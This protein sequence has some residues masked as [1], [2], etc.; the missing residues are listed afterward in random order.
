M[1]AISFRIILLFLCCLTVLPLAAQEKV[2]ALEREVSMKVTDE[3]VNNV[4]QEIAIQAGIKF[5]Y[6]PSGIPASKKVTIAVHKKTVR[7]VLNLLFN[8]TV[9]YRQHGNFIILTA[10][11]P[12]RSSQA[13]PVSRPIRVSGYVYD[14]DGSKLSSAS[15]LSRSE[16]LSAVT[17]Q[18]GFFTLQLTATSFPVELKVE[19]AHY[20]DTTIRLTGYQPN[21]GITLLRERMAQASPLRTADTTQQEAPGPPP[22]LLAAADTVRP[23]VKKKFPDWFLSDK[24]KANLLN[25]KDTL[26]S[27]VQFSLIPSLSTN[28]LLVGNTQNEVSI[29]LLVGYSQS[30]KAVE[31]SGIMNRDAGDVQ[32][33]QIAGL[34]NQVDGNVLGVQVAGLMN[35][36]KQNV[37]HAQFAGLMNRVNGNVSKTQFAGLMNLDAHNFR[38]VQGTGLINYVKDSVRGV[39]MAGLFNSAGY[40]NGMQLAGLFN[41]AA[42]TRTYQV[43]GL[44]NYSRDARFQLSGLFNTAGGNH[45]YQFT[46][47]FNYSMNTVNTQL[48]GLFNA[49]REVRYWQVAG[50]F[51]RA[52]YMRG[53][54]LAIFNFSDSCS[55]VP[56]G[57]FSYSKRG[58]HKLELSGD[59]VLYTQLAF[60]TGVPKLHNIFTAGIRPVSGPY[61]LW[62]FGCGLGSSFR[63]S[64]SWKLSTD[65]VTQLLVKNDRFGSAPLL[66][67]WFVGVERHFGNRFS[68]AAGPAF[69]ALISYTANPA[70]S[71]DEPVPV[72]SHSF[73]NGTNLDTWVGAKLSL[74]F[75]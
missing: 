34:V 59:E 5:S 16:H 18:Y 41:R 4:L 19:K 53:G 70:P 68:V 24:A 2:P 51:N 37:R 35:L 55:G 21:M 28:K 71:I 54:Q 64:Q 56:I 57:V 27:K 8:G 52:A 69:R 7:T 26:F 72:Y 73:S 44:F 15:V 50:L 38:G 33:A 43:A 9:Q 49:C 74:K 65:L 58:Y 48:A 42:G 6:N 13:K 62:G 75:L 66:N 36:D 63:L 23:V 12:Q 22:V 47:L 45:A 67:S 10:S 20:H 29:N 30:V 3:P 31:I 32:Y 40:L 61:T 39:Q 25:V 60:R 1:H 17:D 46:G 14:E 11:G